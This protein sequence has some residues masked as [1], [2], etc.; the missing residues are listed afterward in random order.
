MHAENH[1][2]DESWTYRRKVKRVIVEKS[3]MKQLVGGGGV[4]R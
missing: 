1:R 3:M 2:E 4:D